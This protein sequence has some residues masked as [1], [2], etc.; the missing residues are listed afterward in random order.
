MILQQKRKELVPFR[1]HKGLN[2]KAQVHNKAK[3]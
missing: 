2:K 3:R 1:Q